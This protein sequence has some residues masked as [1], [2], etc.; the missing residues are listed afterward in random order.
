[1]EDK[2]NPNIVTDF[3]SAFHGWCYRAVIEGYREMVKD[4]AAGFSEWEEESLTARLRNEMLKSPIVKAKKIDIVREFYLDDALILEGKKAAKS[5]RRIDFR[6]CSKWTFEEEFEY[7]AEAKNLYQT[8]KRASQSKNY[9]I[10]DGIERFIG[11]FYPQGFML[12]Y[13][14]RGEIEETVIGINHII[15]EKKKISP[16]IGHI[17]SKSNLYAHP[18]CYS[19]SNT[20][21]DGILE[22]RHIFLKF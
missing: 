4:I 16:R 15:I 2:L 12:G 21:V 18:Y 8:G 13:V 20:L 6:F 11:G 14:L 17:T 9:Y 22:L 1:M 7:Y 10:T 3:Q 5:A 19:S